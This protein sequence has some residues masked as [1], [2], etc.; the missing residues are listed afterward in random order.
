MGLSWAG[1]STAGRGGLKAEVIGTEF[2]R[3]TASQ[4]EDFSPERGRPWTLLQAHIVAVVEETMQPEHV[5]LWM[6]RSGDH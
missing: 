2:K 5:S 6:K 3:M 1:W 4:N